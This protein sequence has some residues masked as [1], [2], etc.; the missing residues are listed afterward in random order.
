MSD[1]AGATRALES[2]LA[3]QFPG[4][5]V[6]YGEDGSF[7]KPAAGQWMR[8]TDLPQRPAYLALGGS[9]VDCDGLGVVDIFSSAGTGR[10]AG[11]RLGDRVLAA[12]HKFTVDGIK[13]GQRTPG[14]QKP[15]FPSES[16]GWAHQKVFIPY[17]RQETR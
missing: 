6:Q 4:L 12:F 10:D 17:S 5:P 2:R 7:Q 3:A 1:Y 11:Q 9:L 16:S 13:F 14:W 8:V 15:V